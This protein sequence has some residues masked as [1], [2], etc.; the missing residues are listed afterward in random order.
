VEDTIWAIHAALMAFMS[1][2]IPQILI[3]GLFS[4]YLFL[5]HLPRM[6]K[7]IERPFLRKWLGVQI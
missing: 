6:A 1:N 7:R 2:T 5:L 4:A 3:F